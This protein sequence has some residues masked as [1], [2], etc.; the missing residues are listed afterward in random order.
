[1]TN[2][3]TKLRVQSPRSK[4]QSQKSEDRNQESEVAFATQERANERTTPRLLT[5]DFGPWTLFLDIEGVRN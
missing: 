2:D 5:L 4:V 1:M 3:K